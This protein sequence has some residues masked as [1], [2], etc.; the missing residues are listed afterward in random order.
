MK[1]AWIA[2]ATFAWLTGA[3]AAEARQAYCYAN[4]QRSGNKLERAFGN[5][6][7]LYVTPI[8]PTDASEDLLAAEFAAALPDAGLATCVT[9]EFQTDLAG[10]RQNLVDGSKADKCSIVVAAPPADSA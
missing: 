2:L 3:A 1:P 5:Q 8:F 10:D 4:T 7:S 9:D 6:C